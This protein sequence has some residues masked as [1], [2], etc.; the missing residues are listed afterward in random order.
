VATKKNP[1]VFGLTEFFGNL[2]EL[3]TST[4]VDHVLVY[5]PEMV[6]HENV[7]QQVLKDPFEIKE[8]TL[9]ATGAAFISE[10]LLVFPEGIRV[11]VN[12]TDI[13][14][15]K[16]AATGL[17]TTAYPVDLIN[18]QRPNLGKTVYRKRK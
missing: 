10:P 9:Y 12:Y 3:P 16:G 11:L 8:S 1:V 17:I 4:W 5:H 14:Y 18:Y 2:V 15:Q 13:S 6:G 7:I